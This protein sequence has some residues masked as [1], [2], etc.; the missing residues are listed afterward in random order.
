MSE[1]D[2]LRAFVNGAGVHLP[3]GAT[4]LDA[5]RAADPAAADAVA[6]G[7]RAIADSRGLAIDPGTPLSGG[8]VLR[9]VSSRAR[10]GDAAAT[11]APADASA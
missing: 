10:R 5:V 1:P 9:V 7:E 2:R 8:A 4:L 3:R 11:D 6:R